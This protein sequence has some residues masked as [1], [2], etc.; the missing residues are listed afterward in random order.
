VYSFGPDDK[1]ASEYGVNLQY[2]N[3]DTTFQFRHCRGNTCAVLNSGVSANTS[4][5]QFTMDH[6]SSSLIRMRIDGGQWYHFRTDN[7]AECTSDP[8]HN[9]CGLTFSSS[10]QSIRAGVIPTDGVAKSLFLYSVEAKW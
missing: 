4:V 6:V 1:S 2:T 8:T 9:A 10:N 3:T 7:P 5:H